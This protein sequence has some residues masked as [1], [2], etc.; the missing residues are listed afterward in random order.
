MVSLS[1]CWKATSPFSEVERASCF[2]GHSL[3]TALLGDP[4]HL[5][6]FFFLLLPTPPPISPQLSG[7]Q[8]AGGCFPSLTMELRCGG[9]LFS[10]RFDSG[11]LAHVEK[12]E[13]VS[14]DGE[15]GAGGGASAPISSI[16]SSPDYEFNVW[17]RPDCAETEFEN[18]NR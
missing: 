7:P 18:G 16:A 9:L 10:S 2:S 3:G 11:N 13:S 5:F 8:W 14:S 1:L 4:K 12:V 6:S 17:T 15:G